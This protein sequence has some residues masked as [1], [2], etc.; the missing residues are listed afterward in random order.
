LGGLHASASHR[1]PVLLTEQERAALAKV[2][3]YR[4]VGYAQAGTETR[5]SIGFGMTSFKS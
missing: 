1:W 2:E 3:D 4:L 5:H